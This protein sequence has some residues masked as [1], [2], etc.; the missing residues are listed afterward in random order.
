[1]TAHTAPASFD[2]AATRARRRARLVRAGSIGLAA[3][4]AAAWLSFLRPTA[5]GGPAT[6][7][8]VSGESMLPTLE[9]GDLVVALERQSYAAGDVVVYQVPAGEPGAGTNIVHRIVGRSAGGGYVVRGDNREGVD[10]WHPHDSDI[11]GSMSQRI[12]SVGRP[13]ALVRQPAAMALLAALVTVLVALGVP[14]RR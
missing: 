9:S 13:F 14:R 4:L 3:L 2:L 7:V 11:L 6:Y 10:P 1:M 5:L 8:I 12:P